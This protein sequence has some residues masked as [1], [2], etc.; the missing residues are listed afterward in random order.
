M[1]QL[2]IVLNLIWYICSVVGLGVLYLHNIYIYIPFFIRYWKFQNAYK[3]H[4][5]LF[6]LRLYDIYC[7]FLNNNYY[8]FGN[9][10]NITYGG[11]S[12]YIYIPLNLYDLDVED[13]SI[14]VSI[15]EH[16]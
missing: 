11:S 4:M 10:T 15:E 12:G 13:Y 9:C 2:D 1:P 8:Y 6:M 5:V 16:I 7:F 3:L 14:T